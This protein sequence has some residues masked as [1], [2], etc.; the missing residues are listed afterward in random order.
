MGDHEFLQAAPALPFN[1][2]PMGTAFGCGRKGAA[3]SRSLRRTPRRRTLLSGCPRP[4][5][6]LH[7]SRSDKNRGNAAMSATG[8]APTAIPIGPLEA[9]YREQSNFRNA[10]D[11]TRVTPTHWHIAI[12]NGL[13]WGFDGMD[14]VIFALASPLIIRDFAM[15]PSRIPL[16]AADRAA[17]RH[18]RHVCLAV[19]R[20]PLWAAHAAGAEHRAVLADDAGGGD[21]S[22][23]GHFRCG[24]LRGELRAERRMGARLDAGGR[25]L[26]GASAR[27]G[28]S[29][30]TA[31][32]GASARRRPA[33]SPPS[34]SP[35]TAGASPSRCRRW[36]R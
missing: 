6:G 15:L 7:G 26:A 12:A 22:D 1:F 11:Q 34:S 4:A 27:P 35:I 13:G 31:A 32:R 14:G 16:R 9:R 3:A 24:A 25:N 10:S 19:A 2:G 21:L 5:S 8:L 18:R 23:L 28:R 36:W 20:R 29:A 33:P 30:S 17:D